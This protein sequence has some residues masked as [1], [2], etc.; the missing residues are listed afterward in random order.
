LAEVRIQVPVSADLR[1]VVNCLETDGEE[2]L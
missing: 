1:A 2:V